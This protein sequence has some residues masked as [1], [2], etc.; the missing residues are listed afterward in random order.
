MLPLSYAYGNSGLQNPSDDPVLEEAFEY[1]TFPF[2]FTEQH[3]ECHRSAYAYATY[4]M[5]AV[6]P[7][8]G[9]TDTLA[10]ARPLGSEVTEQQLRRLLLLVPLS[11]PVQCSSSRRER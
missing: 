7:V 9:A 5:T 3:A 8:E 10:V 4:T 11:V 2:T 1:S 6:T